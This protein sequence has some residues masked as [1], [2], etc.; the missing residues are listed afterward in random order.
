MEVELKTLRNLGD[1]LNRYIYSLGDPQFYDPQGN[2]VFTLNSL[3]VSAVSLLAATKT[4]ANWYDFEVSLFN[5]DDQIA[6]RPGPIPLE[7]GAGG[8]ANISGGSG[9]QVWIWH[10]KNVV[11]TTTG[12]HNALVFAWEEGTGAGP[13]TG[14]LL[15]NLQT[16]TGINPWGGTLSFQG[17]DQVAVGEIANEYVL[18]NNDGDTI[19]GGFGAS[20]LNGGGNALVVGGAG[21]DT[22][23]GLNTGL[24]AGSIVNVLVAGSGTDTLAGGR[25][26]FFDART[27]SNIFSYNLGTDPFTEGLSET[28]SGEQRDHRAVPGVQS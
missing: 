20:A 14:L 11:W 9:N 24:L 6:L 19:N 8:T 15:L 12:T 7:V 10:E 23:N 16:G 25:N 18:C 3:S 17:V 21:N 27:V 22:L 4:G 26:T 1:E 2:P 28:G 13:A 5:G